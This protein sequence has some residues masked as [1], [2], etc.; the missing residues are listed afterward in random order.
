MKDAITKHPESPKKI[1][2]GLILKKEKPIIKP[3]II[4]AYT[5]FDAFW[6]TKNMIVNAKIMLNVEMLRSRPS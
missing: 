3:S 6:F 5:I 1:L 2:F 4:K